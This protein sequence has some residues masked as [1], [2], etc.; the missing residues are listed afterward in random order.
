M[1][2][3]NL[4]ENK[5]NNDELEELKKINQNLE[6]IKKSNNSL[7]NEMKSM[8]RR[9]LRDFKDILKVLSEDL[10]KVKIMTQSSIK[11]NIDDGKNINKISN[12]NFGVLTLIFGF[13][14]GYFL[15]KTFFDNLK[16]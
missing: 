16:V 9:E 11:N 8:R 7:L 4:E 6:D 3:E 12:K 14:V 15:L 2:K 10:V 13:I 1:E 5:N